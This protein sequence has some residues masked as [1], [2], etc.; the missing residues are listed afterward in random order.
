[1]IDS[2]LTQN[3]IPDKEGVW[4]ASNIPKV[5]YPEESRQVLF[6]LEENSFWFQHRNKCIKTILSRFSPKE[7]ILDVGG[8]NGFVSLCIQDAGYEVILLEPGSE[9]I[10][11][12][13]KRGIRNILHTTFQGANFPDCSIDS[14]GLFDVLE[15]MEGDQDF[16]AQASDAMKKGSQLYIT[17]PAHQYLW[18]WEDAYSGHFRR[19]SIASLTKAIN[20][21]GFLVK[22][23]SYFFSGLSF[24]IFLSRKL[25]TVLGLSRNKSLIKTEQAHRKHTG[26]FGMVLNRLLSYEIEKLKSGKLPIGSSIIAVAEKS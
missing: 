11:N 8:G 18:S 10:I 4:R 16:L 23:V 7:Y 6:S 9:G 26:I 5:S 24:P 20:R 22:Y 19:Y 1:M 21:S 2:A 13:Q 14:I 12:A 15:H 17:V 3:L 25:P